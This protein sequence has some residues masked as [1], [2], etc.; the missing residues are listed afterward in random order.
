MNKAVKLTAIAAAVA[1]L[2][3]CGNAEK[4]QVKV[5]SEA[6]K[7]SYALGASMGRYLNN[8]LE[9]NAEIGIELKKDMILGGIE[10]ALGDKVQFTEEEI[11]TVMNALEADVRK[12]GMEH[13]EKL[14][15][16][17]QEEGK[18][19]LVE[20]AKRSEVTVTESGLQYEVLSEAEGEKP[21]AADTVTVHYHGTLVDGTVFDSSVDRGQTTSFP[22]NRVIPGWTE[23]L[24]YM[25][26]GSKYKFY[27]PSELGYGARAAGSI[28]PHSTL[29]FEVELFDIQK[30]PAAE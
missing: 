6:D 22:L 28:P 18:Q 3:A 10:D 12:R 29:I 16:A 14:A 25:S 13:Q 17:A 11:E 1:L 2:G 26:K 8:N 19:F 4:A 9:K 21:A 7:Q 24:Q 15:S 30:A 27:I 5:E 23:G 20:N